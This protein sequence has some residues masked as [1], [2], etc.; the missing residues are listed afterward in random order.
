MA[1]KNA[2]D[3]ISLIQTAEGAM[4]EVHSILQRGRELSVQAANDTNVEEDREAI[5]KE[6]EQIKEEINRIGLTTEFN[7]RKILQGA[8]ALGTGDPEIEQFLS[9]LANYMFETAEDMVRNAYGIETPANTQIT[10]KFEEGESDYN[11]YFNSYPSNHIVFNLTN[12]FK[13]SSSDFEPD[14]TVA[15]EMTHAIM[16]A[17]GIW[18]SK[19]PNWF[20]EGTAEYLSGGNDRVR[21]KLGAKLND[22][23]QKAQALTDYVSGELA[24]WTDPDNKDSLDYGASYLAVRYLEKFLNDNGKDT[25]HADLPDL[26][27]ELTKG[28]SLADALNSLTGKTL[29]NFYDELKDVTKAGAYLATIDYDTVGAILSPTETDNTKTVPDDKNP[30][31]TSDQFTYI[32]DASTGH[33]STQ[34]SNTSEIHLLI[35]ANEGQSMIVQLPNISIS[36][37]GITDVDLSTQE[38]ASE[39]ITSFDNAIQ[40]VSEKRAYLGAVQNRLEHTINNLGT[41]AENLSAAE[42]RIRDTDMAKEMMDFTKQNILMQAAQSMLAQAN[43]Q[44][45]GVLQLLQ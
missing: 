18:L 37:L 10:I 24:K 39:A 25:D 14:T 17:S 29:D 9:D 43:Q 16:S 21:Y 3:G 12:M 19:S 44:P 45:Q 4:N 22:P 8:N 6:I 2:Q 31:D 23:A 41:A 20:V 35:G 1:S 40:K 42:S 33:S 34:D 26:M 15:H 13:N 11:A 7:T 38:G 30:I 27:K 36:G 28:G 5:Q 32:W